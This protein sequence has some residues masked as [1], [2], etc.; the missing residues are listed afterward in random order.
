[1]VTAH[2]LE[3]A[4]RAYAAALNTEHEQTARAAFVALISQADREFYAERAGIRQYV[5][6]MSR[7]DAERA[8]LA[9][10]GQVDP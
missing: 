9:D 3:A 7:N 2:D 6:G 10:I 1:M 4:R 8:A 5:G